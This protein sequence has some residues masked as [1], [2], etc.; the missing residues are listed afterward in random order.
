MKDKT[1]VNNSNNW[2]ML[3]DQKE[4][5]NIDLSD[6]FSK[7]PKRSEKY[8]VST[9]H[10]YFDYSRQLIDDEIMYL[11]FELANECKVKEKIN[12]MFEGKKINI[13]ENRAVL[14]TALRNF[15]G[16]PVFVDGN[17]VMPEIKNVL[18]KI[19]IF[20]QEI[21]K[22]KRTGVTGKKIKNI[23]SIGIGGSFLGP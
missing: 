19:K 20:S 10:V 3:A 14:H 13:T 23:I 16:K 2:Q 22:G 9:E 6:E 11:L 17:D 18:E 12:E 1:K 5:R 21:H 8:F 7:D 4:N 15:S